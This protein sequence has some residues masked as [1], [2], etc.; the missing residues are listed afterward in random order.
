MGPGTAAKEGGWGGG[1]VKGF[2][3]PLPI[4]KGIFFPPCCYHWGC[5]VS[6][7]QEDAQGWW[8]VLQG[9]VL[10]GDSAVGVCAGGCPCTPATGTSRCGWLWSPS[11]R[12]KSWSTHRY[13]CRDGVCTGTRTVSRWIT[14][15][16][17]Q[18]R[19]PPPPTVWALGGRT[20]HCAKSP[21]VATGPRVLNSAPHAVLECLCKWMV[22]RGVPGTNNITIGAV[23]TLLCPRCAKKPP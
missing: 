13:R 10:Q 6:Y 23:P 9:V 5:L 17:A 18:T 19:A 4:R 12:Q 21:P 1:S 16:P 20:V 8:I 15:R 3:C 14:G 7:P 2:S 22:F 11:T